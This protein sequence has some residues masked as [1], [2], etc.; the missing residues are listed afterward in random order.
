[1]VNGDDANTAA[2]LTQVIP[3]EKFWGRYFTSIKVKRPGDV[4][5]ININSD[6][7]MTQ[8]NLFIGSMERDYVEWD[9]DLLTTTQRYVA[10]DKSIRENNPA[11]VGALPV[12]NASIDKRM[13]LSAAKLVKSNARFVIP[14]R[15]LCNF[16]EIK[17]PLPPECTLTVELAINQNR[18]EIFDLKLKNANANSISAAAIKLVKPPEILLP[19]VEQSSTHRMSFEQ[20]FNTMQSY[21]I[22]NGFS[23]ETRSKELAKGVS[24]AEITFPPNMFQYRWLEISLQDMNSYKHPTQYC[25]YD[26][27]EILQQ[28]KKIKIS[29]LYAANSSSMIT[30]DVNEQIDV[31]DLYQQ[32]LA[33]YH[34]FGY[35]RNPKVAY[36]NSRII[37]YAVK[38]PG[39]LTSNMSLWID[40]SETRHYTSKPD[41]PNAVVNPN[42][43]I[44][45]KAATT[46]SYMFRITSHYPSEYS[47]ATLGAGAGAGSTKVIKFLPTLSTNMQ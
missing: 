24:E 13:E 1:M 41:P 22:W 30:Y 37:Q 19:L 14:L 46:K 31:E 20:I 26:Y 32:Y 45:F 12:T 11:G 25:N 29:G 15:A 43:K 9:I 34:G 18:G 3:V 33:R 4:N 16:F 39:F 36:K 2:N 17:G 40:I 27:D 8:F 38:L 47:L 44:E 6:D 35:S 10:I 7:L 21:R 23:W 42:I 28:I 5:V